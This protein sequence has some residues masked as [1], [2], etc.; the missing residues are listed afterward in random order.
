LVSLRMQIGN[1]V[2]REK[3]VGLRKVV[4]SH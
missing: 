3:A 4:T 2:V 1:V